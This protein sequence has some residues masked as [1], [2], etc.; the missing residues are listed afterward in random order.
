LA[1]FLQRLFLHDSRPTFQTAKA[2]AKGVIKAACHIHSDWS[3]DGKWSL[4]KLAAEFG[5]RDYGALL[6]TEHDRGFTQARLLE[7]REACA[8]ASSD[9]LLIV[10]GIEYSDADNIVHIL[11]WG[12]VP[13]L[14]EALPTAEL[15]EKVKDAGGI[16]VMAHPSRKEAWKRFDRQWSSKLLGI[17]IWNRKTDGWAPSKTAVPLTDG[18]SFLPFVGLD[19]HARRQFFPLATE[20]NIVGPVTEE[21]VLAELKSRRCRPTAFNKSLDLFLPPGWRRAGLEA[22]EFGRLSAARTLRALTYLKS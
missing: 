22:A 14:G 20:L 18:T 1:G 4:P 3:Y 15:L 19:F 6:M 13:F 5:R 12:A 7:Y 16:A 11:V 21:P 2:G 17:E 8:A 10:P 9:H